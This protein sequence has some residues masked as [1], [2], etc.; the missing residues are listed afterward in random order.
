MEVS[1][2]GNFIELNGRCSSKQ[3]LMTPYCTFHFNGIP[4]ITYL[5]IR[6]HGAA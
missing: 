5:G 4:R 2:T 6:D 1:F 3:C